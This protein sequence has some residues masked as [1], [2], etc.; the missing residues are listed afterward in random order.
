MT[1]VGTFHNVYEVDGIKGDA[2][3]FL[4][5]DDGCR[6]RGVP[7]GH[8]ARHISRNCLVDPSLIVN[9]LTVQC[10]AAASGRQRQRRLCQGTRNHTWT[11]GLPFL[12]INTVL[13]ASFRCGVC[14]RHSA[15][16][17]TFSVVHLCHHRC[18]WCTWFWSRT[19]R[20]LSFSPYRRQHGWTC[21]FWLC[22]GLAR[23]ANLACSQDNRS[24]HSVQ[25]RNVAGCLQPRRPW[26]RETTVYPVIYV[27][28]VPVPHSLSKRHQA[29]S[30]ARRWNWRHATRRGSCLPS[31]RFLK[32]LWWCC[33]N[34]CRNASWSRSWMCRCC[35]SWKKS[36]RLLLGDLLWNFGDNTSEQIVVVPQIREQ[37]VEVIKV[38]LQEQC[39][40]MRFFFWEPV[41]STFRTC[42]PTD[43][44]TR[45]CWWILSAS[46]G[47]WKL[48]FSTYSHT[49]HLVR[50]SGHFRHTY[51]CSLTRSTFCIDAFAV[52]HLGIFFSRV[53]VCCAMLQANCLNQFVWLF[54][55]SLIMGTA[56]EATASDILVGAQPRII[57]AR[58]SSSE[59]VD[60]ATV[61]RRQRV[62][63]ATRVGLQFPF[64]SERW[65]WRAP[66]VAM[67]WRDAVKAA[68]MH[69]P[70]PLDVTLV[71]PCWATRLQCR[72]SANATCLL[73]RP[74]SEHTA[75]YPTRRSWGSWTSTPITR[76]SMPRHSRTTLAGRSIWYR[77]S[78]GP[79]H[80]TH[81]AD[82]MTAAHLPSAADR[83]W[84][85]HHSP[86]RV[87]R[88]SFMPSR[89][90]SVLAYALGTT[91]TAGSCASLTLNSSPA[92]DGRFSF[93]T[94]PARIVEARGY[95]H[96]PQAECCD[97]AKKPKLLQLR[98]I[99]LCDRFGISQDRLWN[100]AETALRG[101][102]PQVSVGCFR[103]A[104][105]RH[106]HLLQTW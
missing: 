100:L 13:F 29:P 20:I 15:W 92:I 46:D 90:G 14:L 47:I 69:G 99:Y 52:F 80:L 39:Q 96:P 8:L 73:G 105:L 7:C 49:S 30:R 9:S 23:F 44:S 82:G 53:N 64:R 50:F 78:S 1:T 31:R 55:N 27:V 36:W 33:K 58:S 37:N 86:T 22:P 38:I 84:N 28:L 6:K 85:C 77:S 21:N 40:Q 12:V 24:F 62:E 67:K 19:T 35:G 91:S 61:R 60:T 10:L 70:L 88:T 11:S 4:G 81:S 76:V 87:L 106:G 41:G 66:S 89:P 75:A 102:F 54:L 17:F 34:S 32:W 2:V 59:L 26:R 79:W 65:G 45:E 74:Q 16:L 97:I 98:V 93:S 68:I 83:P 25:P 103:L 72:W 5:G 104:R 94:Q 43:S 18:D 56:E 95:S 63:D 42:C 71:A 101:W 51:E 3:E 48:L 57:R